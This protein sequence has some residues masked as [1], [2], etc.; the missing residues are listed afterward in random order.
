MSIVDSAKGALKGSTGTGSGELDPEDLV[1][2]IAIPAFAGHLAGVFSFSVDVFGGYVLDDTLFS[3]GTVDLSLAMVVLGAA[4]AFIFATNA[5]NGY[6][7]HS[8]EAKIGYAIAASPLLIPL[9]PA[10]ENAVMWSD[11]TQVGYFILVSG[12]AAF[13]SYDA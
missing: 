12:A 8:G 5:A 11:V 7:D 6:T 10:F 2:L 13:V 4:V 1:A 3:I 9:M